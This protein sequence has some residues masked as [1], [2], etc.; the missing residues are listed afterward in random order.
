[1][2][3]PTA[4]AA[5]V[6]AALLLLPRAADGAPITWEFTG[7][8]DFVSN[9]P[10]NPFALPPGFT[11]GAPVAGGHPP[12]AD[13]NLRRSHLSLSEPISHHITVWSLPPEADSLPTGLSATHRSVPPPRGAPCCFPVITDHVRTARSRQWAAPARAGHAHTITKMSAGVNSQFTSRFPPRRATIHAL[14]LRSH[15]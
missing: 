4:L 11:S 5:T 8:V 9:D 12:R 10:F 3:S 13:L 14:G 6:A 7:T 15:S 2:T 1:M